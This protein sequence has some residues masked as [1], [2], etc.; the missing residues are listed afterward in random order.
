MEQN[1]PM[2]FFVGVLQIISVSVYF[3]PSQKRKQLVGQDKGLL[4]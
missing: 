2:Y 3:S 4:F 1:Y